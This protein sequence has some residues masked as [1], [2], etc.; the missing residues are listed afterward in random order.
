MIIIENKEILNE[1]MRIDAIDQD[2]TLPNLKGKEKRI[3]LTSIT[4]PT[5]DVG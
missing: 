4:K 2:E 5:S 1:W 3:S